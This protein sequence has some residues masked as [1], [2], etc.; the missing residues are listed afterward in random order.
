MR[1][2]H[3]L[4]AL[5]LA[6]PACD[7]GGPITQ[8]RTADLD[9][10]G[11]LQFGTVSVG[12]SVT[13]KTRVSNLGS[14]TLTIDR[15]EAT[16]PFSV[17][18][19]GFVLSGGE[20]REVEVTYAPTEPNAGPAENH[21]GKLIAHNDGEE[22]E[23]AINLVGHAVQAV[24]VAT[25][26]ALDFGELEVGGIKE[27]DLVLE[28]QGTEAVVISDAG[29]DSSVFTTELDKLMTT[30]APGGRIE[31]RVAYL[32]TAG[33]EDTGSLTLVTDMLAGP[34]LV[35][36]LR[37]KGLA[38]RI[39]LCWKLDEEGAEEHC[40]PRTDAG[41]NTVLADELDFGA[42]DQGEARSATLTLKNEGNVQVDLMGLADSS[43]H[44]LVDDTARENPCEAASVT[45][46]F[47]FE[48]DS[49]GPKLPEDDQTETT[50]SIKVTYRPHHECIGDIADAGHLMLKAGRQTGAP[51]F[52]LSLKGASLI[53]L[54]DAANVNLE[55]DRPDQQ[56]Y[57]V[58]NLGSGMLQ[59]T[60]VEITEGGSGIDCT[61]R[62]SGV[63]ARP[64]CQQASTAVECQAFRWADGPYPSEAS[65]LE[66]GPATTDASGNTVPTSAEVGL[67]EYTP[68]PACPP[69]T[70]GEPCDP[71]DPSF[72]AC[73]RIW[74]S[75]PYRSPFCAELQGWRLHVR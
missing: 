9:L 35:I 60:R 28:N 72:K 10:G 67:L 22:P 45:A 14:S 75:D 59:V 5:L 33:R 56:P 47:V 6:L 16:A 73:V 64:V 66:I 48:P 40:L 3:W 49:F 61:E 21:V 52:Y 50:K 43:G 18:A 41:G 69:C 70:P 63:D 53:G 39:S 27:L 2:L 34:Q 74:S 11:D 51:T 65:P 31:T 58:R 32:P 44:T 8:G 17:S 7:C 46:D 23:A 12:R 13:L 54:V 38:A 24:L 26:T 20:A 19:E 68:P 55:V 1:R 4:A 36:P 25:P 71:C 42:L 62:C 30:I 29:I 57:S 15:M 37:G